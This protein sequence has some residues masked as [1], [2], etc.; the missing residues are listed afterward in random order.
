[1]YLV[2]Q[3]DLLTTTISVAVTITLNVY[4]AFIPTDWTKTDFGHAPEGYQVKLVLPLVM[5]YLTPTVRL[6]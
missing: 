1:M 3:L 4:G 2:S 5:Q 6:M